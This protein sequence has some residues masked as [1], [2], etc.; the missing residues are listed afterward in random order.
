MGFAGQKKAAS[1]SR[2]LVFGVVRDDLKWNYMG[3][4]SCVEL[5]VSAD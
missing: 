2:E 1:S 3:I 5:Y 4:D